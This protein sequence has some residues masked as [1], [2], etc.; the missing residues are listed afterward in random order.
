[1]VDPFT[2]VGAITAVAAPFVSDLAKEILT[3]SGKEGGKGLLNWGGKKIAEG[4]QQKLFNASRQYVETY[5]ER[6]CTL[7]VLGMKQPVALRPFQACYTF[8]LRDKA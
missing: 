6:H 2:A 8:G 3:D 7:K 1:M 5:Q 4:T